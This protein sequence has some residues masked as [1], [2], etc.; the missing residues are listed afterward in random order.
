[1]RRSLLRRVF[2]VLLL[3]TFV[4]GGWPSA[5]AQATPSPCM[6]AMDTGKAPDAGLA[7]AARPDGPMPCEDGTPAC[8][9]R[10][11]CLAGTTL[12]SSPPLASPV[13]AAGTV[14]YP[15]AVPLSGGRSIE[16]ELFP[17]ITG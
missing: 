6:M 17:P 3:L 14:R 13:L 12:L 1:M 10:T 2:L 7:K 9:K 16:P 5:S 11:C 4:A 8:M 15:P